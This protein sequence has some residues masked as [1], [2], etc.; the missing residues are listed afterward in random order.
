M[1]D[2]RI[3]QP[4]KS[5]M[6]SGRGG[7]NR[8]WLLEYA[9]TTLQRADPLMGWIGSVG[10]TGQIRVTFDS[11]DDAVAF[12]KNNQ[13]TY[14]VSEPRTRRIKPKSYSDNFAF[15]RIR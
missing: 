10:T 14:H 11:R 3:F 2:V 6:Q 8:K 7:N 4:A 12:A 5:A 9:P 15:D 1:P 13:L